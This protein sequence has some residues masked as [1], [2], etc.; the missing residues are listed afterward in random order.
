MIPFGCKMALQ[1][2]VMDISAADEVETS[3]IESMPLSPCTDAETGTTVAGA[4]LTDPMSLGISFVADISEQSA[5]VENATVIE[6]S[7]PESSKESSL[8]NSSAAGQNTRKKRNANM[9]PM[10]CRTTNATRRET[11]ENAKQ[12]EE[13]KRNIIDQQEEL[14]KRVKMDS[15]LERE[16][17]KLNSTILELKQ[18][19]SQLNLDVGVISKSLKAAESNL[20]KEKAKLVALRTESNLTIDVCMN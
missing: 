17:T 8:S 3:A 5:A 11:V 15:K 19:F 2:Q 9:P 1:V 10:S 12:E 20:S 13:R 16:N 18:K 4:V 14:R 6:D 7:V